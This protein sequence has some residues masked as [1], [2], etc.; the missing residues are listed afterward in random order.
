MSKKPKLNRKLIQ[1]ALEVLGIDHMSDEEILQW[2]EARRKK[3]S[4]ET[5]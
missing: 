5:L 1:W 3:T 2:L 4:D